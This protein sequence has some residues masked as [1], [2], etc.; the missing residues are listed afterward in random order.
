VQLFEYLLD[1]NKLHEKLKDAITE[2]EL[3]ENAVKFIKELIKGKGAEEPVKNNK[4]YLYQVCLYAL[5]I[6]F[7]KFVFFLNVVNI[8][9]IIM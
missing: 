1:K 6:V 5:H 8:F 2:D 7:I 3:K 4:K 9:V